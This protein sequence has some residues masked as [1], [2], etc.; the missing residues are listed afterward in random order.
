MV[1]GG[2]ELYH[3]KK[4]RKNEAVHGEESKAIG[5][6]CGSIWRGREV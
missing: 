6:T 4:E 3:R 1:K 5:Q 2:A